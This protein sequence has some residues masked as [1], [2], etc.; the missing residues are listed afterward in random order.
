MDGTS[1][2]KGLKRPVE[3]PVLDRVGGCLLAFD[4]S[5]FPRSVL[6]HD[7]R[8]RTSEP[9]KQGQQD[10]SKTQVVS[11]LISFLAFVCRRAAVLC[12]YLV[13]QKRYWF[14]AL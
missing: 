5:I 2:K 14:A 10:T 8:R 9:K 1:S 11:T 3:G 12:F 4:R 7:R 6:C 13:S